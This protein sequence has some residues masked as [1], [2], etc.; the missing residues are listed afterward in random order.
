MKTSDL[1]VKEFAA[2]IGVSTNTIR[3][4]VPKGEIL[5]T[6]VGTT[7]RSRNLREAGVYVDSG[8][9]ACI[10]HLL[11]VDHSREV[12]Q[13]RVARDHLGFLVLGGCIHNRVGHR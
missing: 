13:I 11:D 3:R 5:A 6:H 7:L 8:T 1:L 2:F 4:T 10:G 12:L 9:E